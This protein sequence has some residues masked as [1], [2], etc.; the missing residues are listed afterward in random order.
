MSDG[1]GG[2]CV[3]PRNRVFF[4][5]VWKPRNIA[6]ATHARRCFCAAA[7]SAPRRGL[8]LRTRLKA[9]IKRKAD[10][11]EIPGSVIYSGAQI[12]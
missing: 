6:L 11:L 8:Q 12:L 2:I 3:A 9:G 4:L 1:R 5:R 7:I 10:K